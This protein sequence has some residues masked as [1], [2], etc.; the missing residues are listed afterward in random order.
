MI[1]VAFIVPSI[2]QHVRIFLAQIA[3]NPL[4]RNLALFVILFFRCFL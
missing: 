4:S 3:P 2:I 1:E